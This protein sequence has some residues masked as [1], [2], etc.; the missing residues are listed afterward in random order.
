MIARAA[1]ADSLIHVPRGE[2]EIEAGATVQWLML[3]EA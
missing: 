1:A 2:G 3:G